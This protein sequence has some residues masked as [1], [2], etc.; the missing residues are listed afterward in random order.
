MSLPPTVDCINSITKTSHLGGNHLIKMKQNTDLF[1]IEL[2]GFFL[3]YV[4]HIVL[5]NLV[6]HLCMVGWPAETS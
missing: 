2:C 5:D 4:L 3:K 6:Y 1:K